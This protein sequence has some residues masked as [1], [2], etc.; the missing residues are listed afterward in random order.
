[1]LEETSKMKNLLQRI[2]FP[3][4]KD[5]DY[6]DLFFRWGIIECS[7]F[8]KKLTTLN[9][10]HFN[11]WMNLFAAK[12]WFHY[13]VLEDLSLGL[14]IQGKF[15][16]EIIGSNRNTAYNRIDEKIFF[17]E[18]DGNGETIYIPI[19]SAKKYDAVYFIL[20]FLKDAPCEIISAGWFTDT[21]PRNKNK[22]A[23]VTCTYKREDYINRT[24]TL[25]EKYLDQNPELQD[26]MHLFISDNGQTLD[27]SSNY[28]YTDIFYNINAGGAGGFGRGLI[29]VCKSKDE[30][31]RC[32][33]MDDDVEII[34]ESFYRTLVLSDYLKEKYQSAHING[35]MLDLYNKVQFF[36]NLAVQDGLWVHTYHN[37]TNLL[38][39]DEILRIN[40]I[41]EIAYHN[42][43]AKTNAAWFYSCFPINKNES[44]NTLPLPIFIRGDDVEWGWRNY[45]IDFIQLNGI[46]IWHAPFYFRVNKITENYYTSRNMFIINCIYTNNFKSIFINLYKE[47]FKYSIDTYDYVSSRLMIAALDD[48]LKGSKLFDEDPVALMNKLQT[49]ANENYETV[50]SPYELLD[51]KYKQVGYSK[52]RRLINKVIR[53]CYR[54]APFTKKIIKRSGTNAISE[55]YPPTDAFLIQKNVRVYN[56]LNHSSIV[57]HFDA[58]LENQLTKEF[59]QKLSQIEKEY[60]NLQKDYKSNFQ[61]ITSYDFWKNY[62]KLD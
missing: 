16:V 35:A 8:T 55:W 18:F 27:L 54:I 5:K 34:P 22:L 46:C 59:N 11:T 39:Y 47:K 48:I 53:L 37:E 38:N 57:R 21:E 45:G 17:Q 33:F 32:L 13:C 41:P 60:D 4:A 1:M 56:L 20:R 29:E 49:L 19:N 12:K 7:A 43:N 30:Y 23:I 61:R 14:C 40:F 31:T 2:I 9:E 28:K 3:E 50:E 26:R 6:R 10:L 58:T 51:V 36:D 52:V 44:I 15:S 62:L 42:E 24:I 25:F